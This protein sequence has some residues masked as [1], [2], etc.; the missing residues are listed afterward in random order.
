MEKKNNVKVF[1]A[2]GVLVVLVILGIWISRVLV[3]N[4]TD[5][6]ASKLVGY[7][8]ALS[9]SSTNLSMVESS[10]VDGAKIPLAKG[11]EIYL[12][13]RKDIVE[14]NQIVL[15]YLVI[16]KEQKTKVAYLNEAVFFRSAE[17]KISQ[18]LPLKKGKLIEK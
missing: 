3:E 2:A 5:A 15:E 1:V 16:N 13:D 6:Y 14:S 4:L 10:F 18:I 8:K 12:L 17:P 9:T 7:Y 11:Y